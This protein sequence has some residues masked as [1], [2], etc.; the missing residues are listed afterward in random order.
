MSERN[1]L[2]I[3]LEEKLKRKLDNQY[4]KERRIDTDES[5]GNI[6]EFMLT[7]E[8]QLEQ[9]QKIDKYTSGKGKDYGNYQL[10][11]KD[12]SNHLQEIQKYI[13]GMGIIRKDK[14]EGGN[15]VD[16]QVVKG[17]NESPSFKI[18]QNSNGI[19]YSF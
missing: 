3:E 5:P 11:D 1:R 15:S 13:E 7:K 10:A 4:E 9:D 2:T 8:E 18:V 17:N 6:N 14:L 16:G 12:T 19:V